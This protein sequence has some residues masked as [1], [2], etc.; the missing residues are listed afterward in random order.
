MPYAILR[1]ITP[2]IEPPS[3]STKTASG[4]GIRKPRRIKKAGKGKHRR[5]L[6]KNFRVVRFLQNEI[7]HFY[8]YLFQ[9]NFNP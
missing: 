6:A 7:R 3:P 4:A 9:I 5:I 1:C 8:L 2:Q